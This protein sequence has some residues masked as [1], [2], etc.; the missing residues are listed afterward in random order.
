MQVKY[1]AVEGAPMNV[2]VNGIAPGVVKTGL[3]QPLGKE[4]LEQ[5]CRDAHL[6]KKIITADQVQGIRTVD[7]YLKTVPKEVSAMNNGIFHRGKRSS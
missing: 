4:R 3:T 7:G 6:T 2:R 1:G 5:I